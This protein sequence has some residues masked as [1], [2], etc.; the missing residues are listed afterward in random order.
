MAKKQSAGLLVYRRGP[1]G[2]E[3]L[4]VHPGG[5]FWKN[6]DDGVWSIPK[7]EFDQSEDA[8]AGAKREFQEETG[9]MIDGDFK[10]LASVKQKSGK[11][12]H[13]W[14]VEADCT[15]STVRSNTFSM[16]WPP[17]SGRMQEFSEIDR[18][19]WFSLDRARTKIHSGQTPLLDEFMR[20]LDAKK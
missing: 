15:V 11:I 14:A 10:P 12:V 7:G 5:P 9:L 8:L 4:L 19:E 3:V 1:D 2:T 20:R 6:K 16:E 18:A 17:K 13:A